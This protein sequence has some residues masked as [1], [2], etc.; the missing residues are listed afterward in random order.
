MVIFNRDDEARARTRKSLGFKKDDIVFI[1]VGGMSTNKG[2][3]SIFRSLMELSSEPGGNRIK[4]LLKGDKHLYESNGRIMMHFEKL[5]NEGAMTSDDANKFMSEHVVFTDVTLS[6]ASLNYFY[7]AADAYLSPYAGEG[8][9]LPVLEAI[10]SGI[11][12]FVSENGSTS[13]YVNT[14]GNNTKGSSKYIF[15]IPAEMFAWLNNEQFAWRY[16]YVLNSIAENMDYLVRYNAARRLE[17]VNSK[18]FRSV[19]K[20][21]ERVHNVTRSMYSWDIVSRELIDYFRYVIRLVGDP[22]KNTKVC[23]VS[24]E[25]TC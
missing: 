13:G 1:N 23:I 4:L 7:N 15:I 6:F 12:T 17:N 11:P 5:I 8:F 3:E 14:I 9:N 19:K 18:S 25:S 22:E 21:Y 2:I 24:D 10:S 16:E 20:Y